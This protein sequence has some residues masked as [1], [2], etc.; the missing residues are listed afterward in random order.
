MGRTVPPLRA[1]GEV[2]ADGLLRRRSLRAWFA[3]GLVVLAAQP[4]PV[5]LAQEAAPDA[6]LD[7]GAAGSIELEP[8]TVEGEAPADSPT[9][10]V[11]GYV[12]RETVTGSK[13]ATPV[14]EIPQSLSVV[15]RDQM[16]DRAVQNV[17]QALEYSAGVVA[18]PFGTDVRFDSPI[19]RGFSAANSQY[20]NGLKLERD[21]GM[22]A[23]EPYGLE[24]I[25]VLRGPS[26]VLYGQGNPGG[27][28]NLVGKRPVWDSFGEINLEAGSFNNFGGSFDVGGPLQLGSAVA[29]RMTALIRDSGTQMDD[30]DDTRYFFA[31]AITWQPSDEISLSILTSVQYDKPD[32]PVGLPVEYTLE[33]SGGDRLARSSY[34]GDPG[35]EESSRLLAS[36]GYEFEYR[37]ADNATFRQNGRYLWLDWNF[38]SLYFN[39]LDPA[40]PSIALRGASYEDETLRTLT[41]DNQLEIE[42][43]TGPLSHRLLFGVDVRHHRSDVTSEFGNA[44]SV[45]VFHPEYD[46]GIPRDIWYSATVEGT[47][48]QTGLYAQD[49]VLLDRWL[50]TLGLRH[51]WA[52]TDSTT[53][54]NFGDSQQDQRDSATTWRVGLSYLFDNGLAPYASYST[55]FEPVLGN[56]PEALGGE[57]FQPSR[58]KQYELGIK[59][60]PTGWNGFFTAAL[61]DLTQTNV[62]STELIDGVSHTVQNGEVKV[63]G[64][65]LSALTSLADGLNL[66]LNYSY[67]DAEITAGDNAGK[68]PANVPRNAANAWLEYEVQGGDL[69]GLSLGGGLRYLGRRYDLD[70]NLN[71][72]G[73]STL[74]DAAISYEF[75]HFKASL[76]VNNIADTRYV[77]SCGFFGCYY[78]DGRTIIGQLSYR[79]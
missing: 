35:F 55:S 37:F 71:E 7:A 23:I 63:R 25:E 2:S 57:P 36:V 27:L 74:F 45:N 69:A 49:Q 17:G 8:L 44:P 14:L 46:L 38:Q 42:A 19:I 48:N 43:T 20:L 1:A 79:W 66:I 26:S 54:S 77:A 47:L 3:A 21:G 56:L 39:G 30:V 78:G 24:R 67:T 59:Y 73:A 22:S 28:I 32:T 64:L 34:L 5:A 75:G 9:G 65:E 60:Q 29:Y 12:A 31:P 41:L 76:N 53:T 72:L 18:Q 62:E 61:Y 70:Q 13:T 4:L 6:A 15:T 33:A 11:E 58:G 50:L 52:G 68:Q 51:D 16:D 10:P 40:D